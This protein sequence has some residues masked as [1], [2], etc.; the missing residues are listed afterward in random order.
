MLRWMER[1]DQEAL[2]EAR[3]EMDVSQRQVHTGGRSVHIVVREQVLAVGLCLAGIRA[4]GRPPQ[5]D[6]WD[7]LIWQPTWSPEAGTLWEAC[8]L[9]DCF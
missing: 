3:G 1:T 8:G 7:E 4:P 6:I 9:K 2:M 5:A